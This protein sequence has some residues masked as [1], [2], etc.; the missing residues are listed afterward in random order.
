MVASFLADGLRC[1]HQVRYIGSGSVEELTRQ[2]TGL[3]GV[4][5]ASSRGALQ[6]VSLDEMY[7]FDAVVDPARQ[8]EA[9]AEA[10]S[11][12]LAEGYTGLRVAAEVTPLVRT[13]AQLDAFA[14]YEHL[15]DHYIADYP[16]S[17][18][19]AY[20]R[21]ELGDAAITQL[22]CMHPAAN[23]GATMFRLHPGDRRTLTLG[24]E[25]DFTVEEA[26]TLALR[27]VHTGHPDTNTILIDASRLTFID[28][29]G[30][31]ALD[32][33]G[34]ERGARIR[35]I[36]SRTGTTARVAELLGLSALRVEAGI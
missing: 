21:A 22:A 29:R 32:A 25:V 33:F 15:V 16:F 3:A 20:N 4:E 27:R 6:V 30:L 34:R 10:T 26:F 13:A 18:L 14:R 19:C 1:G 23:S 17:A 7:R 35:L 8:V 24:G 11:Q 9:Y 12:A 28:H 2:L 5:E 31:L 36:G